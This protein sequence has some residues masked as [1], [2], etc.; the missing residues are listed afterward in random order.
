MWQAKEEEVMGKRILQGT[1]DRH[2][3]PCKQQNGCSF[4]KKQDHVF[5]AKANKRIVRFKTN[6]KQVGRT[7][8]S[9]MHLESKEEGWGFYFSLYQQDLV[10]RKTAMATK[11]HQP[12]REVGAIG[13]EPRVK[14]LASQA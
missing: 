2:T 14:A 12:Q 3:E 13:M 1:Q 10:S 11:I 9:G 7:E 6:K 5:A 8:P 4:S